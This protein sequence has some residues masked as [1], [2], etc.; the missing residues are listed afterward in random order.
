MF[1]L[2]SNGLGGILA[3]DMG[4][5]KTLQ[6]LATLRAL[7][8][9]ALVV[10]PSSLVRNWENEARKFTPDR[11]VLV[12]DG[13]ERESLFDRIADADLVITSYA[14]LRRDA[15]RYRATAFRV[16]VLDEA[17]HIKN[18]DT[19]NARTAASIRADARFV[20][21][22]TP[23]ENSVRDLWSILEFAVPGY[24]GTRKEFSERYEKPIQAGGDAAREV[25][26]RLGRRL[27]PLMLRRMKSEVAPDLPARI[28]NTLL[29][30]LTPEQ[31][32]VYRAVLEQ[33]RAKSDEARRSAGAGQ[34]RMVLLA[35]LTRL[36]Q[37]CCDL[38]P[39]DPECTTDGVSAKLPLFEELLQEAMDGGHRV[40]VFSQFVRMLSLL[41]KRLEEREIPYTYLDGETKHRQKVVD[42]FQNSS[43][44]PVFLISLRAGG[45]GLNLTAADTVI[46]FD[47]WWNPS[48][49]AQATDRAH[50]IGQTSTV[51][52]YRLIT[53]GTVEE[54]IVELQNKKRAQT[55]A[56]LRSGGS[57][58]E[59]L[60]IEDLESLLE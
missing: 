34:A 38:R 19:Q 50:R 14:L 43:D 6:S 56:V 33:S 31:E 17:N 40:L 28:E 46:H 58:D 3:D 21:T 2:A 30:D 39:L 10:C 35:A 13:A 12:I 15:D 26:V 47:P 16:A 41:R 60:T 18:P 4:L 53:R 1:T 44:I 22:G 25:H 11:R 48:V 52:S 7:G 24:L 27:K 37:T 49:E 32:S 51:T 42:R 45:T 29:A 8:G 5:G 57:F 54:K 23:I 59:V 9:K 55:E 36:R 20:L